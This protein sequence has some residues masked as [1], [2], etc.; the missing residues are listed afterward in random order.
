M[1]PWEELGIT[2]EKYHAL[3]Y[4]TNPTD[5]CANCGHYYL[6]HQVARQGRDA[7]CRKTGWICDNFQPM[8]PTEPQREEGDENGGQH[9]ENSQSVVNAPE[10]TKGAHIISANNIHDW[11]NLVEQL[12]AKVERYEKALKAVSRL[13]Y[14]QE[15]NALALMVKDAL[16][17][18]QTPINKEKLRK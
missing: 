3:N 14:L 17:P 2:K 13:D 15:H 12:T 10:V 1:K 7:G 11:A 5:I 9:E 18:P 8:K 16:N 6:C 4:M